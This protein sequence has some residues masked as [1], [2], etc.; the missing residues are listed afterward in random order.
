MYSWKEIAL[1]YKQ[2]VSDLQDEVYQSSEVLKTGLPH[3]HKEATNLLVQS[4]A[5][6]ERN[7]EDISRFA[8]LIKDP[9]PKRVKFGSLVKKEYTISDEVRDMLYPSGFSDHSK[10]QFVFARSCAMYFTI[11]WLESSKYVVIDKTPLKVRHKETLSVYHESNK[12][13]RSVRIVWSGS[14]IGGRG[15][16]LDGSDIGQLPSQ[17]YYLV[18]LDQPRDDI[19]V[20]CN[21]SQPNGTVE[22]YAWVKG[23]YIDRMMVEPLRDRYKGTKGC[24]I[25]EKSLT[26]K[27]FPCSIQELL[28]RD[29]CGL[30]KEKREKRKTP[31]A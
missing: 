6:S 17:N 2:E 27:D 11:K 14:C 20:F 7:S 1:M 3:C 22:I 8:E 5:Q 25:Q 15:K 30:R 4:L 26:G 24:I 16:Y 12:T 13:M 9:E 10:E 28:Q 23:K 19:Y 21:Y 31:K 18:D 29:E